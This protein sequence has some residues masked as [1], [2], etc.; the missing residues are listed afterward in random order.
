MKYLSVEVLKG[1]GDLRNIKAC[2]VL[3]E[4]ALPLQVHKQLAP[5][6]VFQ[7]QVQLSLCLG[8]KLP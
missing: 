2:S 8:R 6:Q 7:N 1:K 5:A 3:K 4:Y